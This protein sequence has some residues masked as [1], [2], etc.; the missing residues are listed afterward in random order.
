MEIVV[1]GHLS[2]DL[3]VTPE[4]ER[5]SLGGGTA[6]AMI[7][8]HLGALAAG[9]VTRVGGFYTFAIYPGNPL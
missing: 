1:V 9:I 2:R 7:A 5:E 4:Y 3:I 6:Y 8:P